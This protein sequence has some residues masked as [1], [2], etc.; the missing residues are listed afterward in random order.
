MLKFADEPK[1]GDILQGKSWD[2]KDF[3]QGSYKRFITKRALNWL[4][5]VHAKP[6]FAKPVRVCTDGMSDEQMKWLKL[7]Q[8]PIIKGMM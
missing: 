8:E 3:F 6:F 4:L 2:G 5:C 7:A 1:E